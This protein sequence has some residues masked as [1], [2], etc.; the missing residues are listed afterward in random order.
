MTNNTNT[1]PGTND[2]NFK[3]PTI[4]FVI[5]I[6]CFIF[7]SVFILFRHLCLIDANIKYCCPHLY[8]NSGI[9]Y[10]VRY[11]SDDS[12]SDSDYGYEVDVEKVEDSV[13]EIKKIPTFANVNNYPIYCSICQEE[14][15]NTVKID[16]GHNFCKECIIDYT[17]IGN[18]CPN[19]RESIRNIYEIEV[20]VFK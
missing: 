12:D 3:D 6:F 17:K 16:C 5:L 18:N 19:C 20:L 4:I 14:Q 10:E 2:I 8:R 9:E 1:D 11:N 13:L 7:T 15:T